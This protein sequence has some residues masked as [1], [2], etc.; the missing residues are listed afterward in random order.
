MV[1]RMC[2]DLI[3]ELYLIVQAAIWH[4]EG[5]KEQWETSKVRH[6]RQGRHLKY[7][8]VILWRPPSFCDSF[9]H[10]W[11][12]PKT[13][14]SY[15]ITFVANTHLDNQIVC[16]IDKYE[17]EKQKNHGMIGVN[18]SFECFYSWGSS[19]IPER[20]TRSNP[21]LWDKAKLQGQE[22]ETDGERVEEEKKNH[23]KCCRR[24]RCIVKPENQD[25][26]EREGGREIEIVCVRVCVYQ[27]KIKT[28]LHK[29]NDFWT[30]GDWS[31]LA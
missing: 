10:P 29:E 24:K 20:V 1:K 19:L 17:Q 2:K 12:I 7:S 30:R 18:K 31:V 23:Q 8:R 14:M 5:I 26:V 3:L 9:K 21:W 16:I 22:N 4:F 27:S 13:S 11:T 6:L 25:A 28:H 15:I